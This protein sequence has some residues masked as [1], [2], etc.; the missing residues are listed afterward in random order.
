[1][2]FLNI[3]TFRA[4]IFKNVYTRKEKTLLLIRELSIF[5]FQFS[6]YYAQLV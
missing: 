2:L 6:I 3:Y 4:F 1:M 5:N